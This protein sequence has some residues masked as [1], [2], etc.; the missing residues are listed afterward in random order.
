MRAESCHV[1][2]GIDRIKYAQGRRC[3]G[4]A[5]RVRIGISSSL[6]SGFLADLRHACQVENLFV[7][8]KFAEGGPAEHVRRRPV[9]GW[10]PPSRPSL[11]PPAARRLAIGKS[12]FSSF[13]SEIMGSLSVKR[14]PGMTYA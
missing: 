8:L 9:I 7:R 11:P 12:K 4:K 3:C 10:I 13:S 1:R 14:S 6:A 2:T 5:G